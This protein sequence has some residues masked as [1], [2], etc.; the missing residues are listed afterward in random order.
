MLQN[1]KLIAASVVYSMIFV[2]VSITVASPILIEISNSLKISVALTGF[3][4]TFLSI[5]YISGAALNSFVCKY[6]ERKHVYRT[7]LFAQFALFLIFAI[8][9]NIYIAFASFF[10]LGICCGFLDV[11]VN[12]VIVEM[13]RGNPGISLNLTHMF[14]GLGAFLGPTISSQVVGGGLDWSFAVFIVAGL[15]LINFV[16]SLFLRIPLSDNYIGRKPLATPGLKESS[17]P[18]HGRILP[19]LDTGLL[20]LIIFAFFAMAATQQ[21]FSAWMPSF[22]RIERGYSS[23]LAGQSLSFF[24]AMLSIGRLIVGIISRRI[25]LEKIVILLSFFCFIFAFISVYSSNKV[26]AFASFLL[27]GAFHSG[28]WPSLLAMGSIYFKERNN[29][30]ISILSAVGS[31]GGLF[32]VSFISFVYKNTDN[33]QLGLSI[34]ASFIFIAFIILVVFY[35]INKARINAKVQVN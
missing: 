6:I 31:L 26:L 20:L 10:M 16:L 30:V 8:S 3:L 29:F 5:G 17:N 34:V 7:V 14:F 11:I 9:K 12:T 33:L 1:K 28:I 18:N 19:K 27:M 21:G 24:W 4:F 15:V 13:F 22:L 2:A 32:A 25:R 35:L 23:I